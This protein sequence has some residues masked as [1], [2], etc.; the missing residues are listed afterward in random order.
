MSLKG[1][2]SWTQLKLIHK[3]KLKKEVGIYC[4]ISDEEALFWVTQKLA[5]IKIN[6]IHFPKPK[7][8]TKAC[9]HRVLC[10]IRPNYFK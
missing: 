10:D 4:F 1:E 8:K 3:E 6:P 5:Q 7:T 2:K 9:Q